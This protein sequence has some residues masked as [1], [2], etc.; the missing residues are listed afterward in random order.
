MQFRAGGAM[1]GYCVF[2]DE[3]PGYNVFYLF[4]VTYHAYDRNPLGRYDADAGEVPDELRRLSTVEETEAYL[5]EHDALDAEAIEVILD[6][7]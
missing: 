7:I 1:R 6:R 2:A 4:R 3:P 5:A